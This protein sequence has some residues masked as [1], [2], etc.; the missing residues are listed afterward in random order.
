MDWLK[1]CLAVIG[2][3]SLLLV[4]SCVVGFAGLG[5]ILDP[6]RASVRIERPTMEAKRAVEDYLDG[7]RS[8]SFASR[9]KVDSMSDGTVQ[10]LIGK[11]PPYDMTMSVA[12]VPDGATA[13]KVTADYNAD[14]LAWSQPEKLLSTNLHRCLRDDFE[15]FLRTVH[16]GR[17]GG[18]LDL[19]DLIERSR[20]GNRD[21]KCDLS[22]PAPTVKFGP[23][24]RP[25]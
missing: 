24:T 8:G 5:G 23:G 6:Q 17:E 7:A 25:G 10:L 11:A 13:T 14:R 2:L 22:T 9:A 15:R 19:D 4:G 16:N 18:R 1:S 21:L 20:R 3:A 12:F